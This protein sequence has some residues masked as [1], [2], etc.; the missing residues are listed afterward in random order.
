[1]AVTNQFTTVGSQEESDEIDVSERPTSI[2]AAPRKVGYEQLA[3][4]LK[5]SKHSKLKSSKVV[6]QHS[7]GDTGE[8]DLKMSTMEK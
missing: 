2:K 4:S 5:R 6:L 3:R 8:L 1:V 7:R